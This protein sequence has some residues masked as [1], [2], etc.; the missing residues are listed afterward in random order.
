M[1]L[2]TAKIGAIGFSAGQSV[3]LYENTDDSLATMLADAYMD[4][5]YDGGGGAINLR[6][7]DIIFATCAEGIVPLQVVASASTGVT[8]AVAFTSEVVVNHVICIDGVAVDTFIYIGNEPMHVVDIKAIPIVAGSDGGA[9]SATVKRCQG[10]EA[11]SA[12]DDLLATTKIDLKGTA[13]TVQ[14]PALT[15]TT[16]NLVLAAGD[17]LAVDVTGTL[18]AVVCL[19]TVTLKK[20]GV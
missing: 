13:N 3:Y 7:N 4:E 15:D 10:T 19:V 8:L 1:S 20:V 16:A 11:P 17:R 5:L 12:G 18:T 9:V 2:D 6:A 14:D